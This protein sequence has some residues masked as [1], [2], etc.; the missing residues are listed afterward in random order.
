[1]LQTWT[2]RTYYAILRTG[3]KVEAANEAVYFGDDVLR[4]KIRNAGLKVAI[5][6][7]RGAGLG[8][9]QIIDRIN[10]FRP[11]KAK[12]VE[13]VKAYCEYLDNGIFHYDMDRPR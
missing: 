4:G 12:T 6:L 13:E 8:V 10:R 9:Y 7:Y 2:V 5:E 11:D 1:M 3:R